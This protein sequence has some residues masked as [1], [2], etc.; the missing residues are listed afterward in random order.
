MV[1]VTFLILL[2][3]SPDGEL[4]MSSKEFAT[5]QQCVQAM[6]SV[7]IPASAAV[8]SGALLDFFPMC[9]KARTRRDEV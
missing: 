1:S 9:P 2:F 7:T 3:V 4:G 6:P 8:R 5:R